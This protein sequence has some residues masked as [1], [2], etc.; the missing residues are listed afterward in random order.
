MKL[1]TVFFREKYRRNE[2]SNFIFLRAFFVSKSIS[3]KKKNLLTN[4]LT[5][6][7]LLTKELPMKHFC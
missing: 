4:L 5:D 2:A 1:H 7:K 3:N 6:K